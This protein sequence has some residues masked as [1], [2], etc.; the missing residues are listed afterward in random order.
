V[1]PKREYEETIR[2]QLGEME[3]QNEELMAQ[4]TRSN[5]EE[6][7]TDLRIKQESAKAKLAELEEARGEAWQNLRAQLDRAVSDVQ[8]ALFVA[9]ADSE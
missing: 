8:N 9:T 5:Y 6:H 1:D 4:A 2:A 3:A 7:L